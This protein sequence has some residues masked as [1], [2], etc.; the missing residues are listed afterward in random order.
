VGLQFY[1]QK[2]A[3]LLYDIYGTDG[4]GGNLMELNEW[5]FVGALFSFAWLLPVVPIV[6]N[7]I[8]APSRAG[9]NTPIKTD[10]YEC[11]VETV[12]DTWGQLKIQYYLYALIFLVFDVEM[13]FLFP[14]AV[15]Y[16]QLD[17]FGVAVGVIFVLLLLEG[18]VYAWRKGALEWS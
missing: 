8:I 9:K 10:V 3:N 15:A 6:A 5:A 17:Y 4:L 18:L 2:L 14:W 13:V 11:G 7:R 12:G 1:S 16:A